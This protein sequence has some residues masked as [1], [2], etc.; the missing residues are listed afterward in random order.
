VTDG[1]KSAHR[2]VR[3]LELLAKNPSGLGFADICARLELPKSSAHALLSTL[4][5]VDFVRFDPM[6]RRYFV[7]VRAFEVGQAFVEGL[8]VAREALPH[9]EALRSEVNETAQLAILDQ[10]ENVY[11]A[12]VEASHHLKLAS[13]VGRR[14]PAHATALGKVMLAGLSDDEVRDRYNDVALEVFTERTISTVPEL[15][16]HLAQIRLSGFA[17]DEG[18]H[19]PGVYCTAV[20][21]RDHRDH[22]VAAMSIS[23][24][25]VRNSPEA[26]VNILRSLQREALSLSQR[27]GCPLEA[28]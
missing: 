15:I 16:Q 25:I 2:V 6:A 3:L 22:V 24:P 10:V 26:R 21:I 18:E 7:G 28:A 11:V 4:V 8:D 27:L 23:V 17:L 19:T 14:I 9:L 1:V 13:E 5:N 20:P 12:K